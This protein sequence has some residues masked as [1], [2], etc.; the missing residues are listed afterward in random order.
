MKDF[1][2][3]LV[4]DDPIFRLI[5][6]K[7]VETFPGEKVRIVNLEN[8]LD[9][10]EYFRSCT[11]GN[12]PALAFIDLNMPVMSGWELLDALVEER[13]IL[14]GKIPFYILSS[15][16]NLAD[17]ERAELYNFINGFRQKPLD[18]E[19]LYTTISQALMEN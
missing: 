2:I 5:F 1:S 15:S 19:Q 13:N 14:A 11:K 18:R 4:D 10:I 16:N 9:A 7:M 8:G 3:A 6:K 12:E 17:R